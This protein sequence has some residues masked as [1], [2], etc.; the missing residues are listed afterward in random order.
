MEPDGEGNQ[1][2]E[3][4]ADTTRNQ[5]GEGMYVKMDDPVG[6]E[7]GGDDMEKRWAD[8]GWVRRGERGKHGD[9]IT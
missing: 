8:D 1:M 6:Q 5:D 4:H 9:M 7:V 2:G 3:V